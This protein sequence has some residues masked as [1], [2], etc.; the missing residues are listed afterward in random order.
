MKQRCNMSS[1]LLTLVI[2]QT[3][4]VGVRGG[5]VIEKVPLRLAIFYEETPSQKD[6]RCIE[7]AAQVALRYINNDSAILPEHELHVEPYLHIPSF[8]SRVFLIVFL[9][10]MMNMQEPTVYLSLFDFNSSLKHWRDFPFLHWNS[11][12]LSLIQ[13]TAEKKYI[14]KKTN[15]CLEIYS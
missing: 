9:S 7:A 3:M 8:V 1:F 4:F 10:Y 13:L 6:D 15:S 14:R 5:T 11:S 2:M 12:F